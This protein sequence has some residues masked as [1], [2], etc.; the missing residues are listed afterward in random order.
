MPV[1]IKDCEGLEW[2]FLADT[3]DTEVLEPR[4][5]SEAK[6][7][8]DW[9]LWEQAI[10]EELA[11]LKAAGTWHMEELPPRVNVIGSKWVFK[12]KND[13]SGWVVCYKVH[14]VAQG[15]S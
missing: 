9:A 7:R 5:L 6:R 11:S 12:A 3:T 4:T 8:L 2:A 10:E 15:F 13:A 1:L 14:L